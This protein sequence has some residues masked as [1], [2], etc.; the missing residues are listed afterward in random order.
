L[1]HP[2]KRNG[3]QRKSKKETEFFGFPDLVKKIFHCYTVITKENDGGIVKERKMHYKEEKRPSDFFEKLRQGAREFS[4]RQRMVCLFIIAEY[5]RVA[6]LTV[7]QLAEEAQVS[8]ATVVRTVAHLGY[9]SYGAL[10]D[11]IQ[12]LLL[13]TRTSLWWQLEES[14]KEEASEFSSEEGDLLFRVIATNAESIRNSLSL[15]LAEEFTRAVEC[16]ASAEHIALLG[17]RS[18]RGA[19]MYAFSLLQQFRKNVSCPSL[20]GADEIYAPLMDLTPRDAVLALSVGGPHYAVSTV[21][22]VRF[23]HERS[24]KVVLITNDLACPAVAW[25]DHV[26]CVSA[27]KEHYSV[28]PAITLL[29]AL[30]V[31]LG[32]HSREEAVEKLRALEKVLGEKKLTL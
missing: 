29:E 10:Q 24:V 22:A 1:P 7:E 26:L 23:A 20:Q 19:I 3:S 21:E 28:V 8:A 14:W 30:V 5:Q 11:E 9:D 17:M 25:A 31:A 2:L 32:K 4:Q 27:T 18:S 6:F 13:M 12:E 15:H 16:L